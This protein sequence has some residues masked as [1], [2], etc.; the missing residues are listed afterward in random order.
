MPRP[1]TNPLFAPPKPEPFFTKAVWE[2]IKII[3][4]HCK[5][6]PAPA[7]AKLTK[8]KGASSFP[9]EHYCRKHTLEI[10]ITL[11]HNGVLTECKRRR[12]RHGLP[13][14]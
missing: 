14:D 6:C 2:P 9:A 7:M 10:A 12:W 11:H 8:H 1:R 5:L 13:A 3:G 4:H